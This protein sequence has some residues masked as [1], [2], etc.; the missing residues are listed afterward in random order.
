[1]MSLDKKREEINKINEE[2][3]DLFERRLE[4]SREIGEIKSKKGL[5]IEDPRREEKIIKDMIEKSH[6]YPKEV[7]DFF[8]YLFKAS[9]KIQ[10]NL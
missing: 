10:K 3:L 2:L 9:K 7:E 1:M 6:H 8:N 5:P 4:L